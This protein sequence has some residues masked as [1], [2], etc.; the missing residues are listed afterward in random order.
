[1][2]STCPGKVIVSGPVAASSR[3]AGTRATVPMLTEPTSEQRQAFDLIG[4]V[5]PLA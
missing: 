5:I 2:R 1:M 3:F 4:A